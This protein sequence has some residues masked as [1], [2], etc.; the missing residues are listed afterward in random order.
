MLRLDTRSLGTIVLNAAVVVVCDD[1]GPASLDPKLAV[2]PHVC[3]PESGI[4]GSSD[5][6][7]VA[8]GAGTLPEGGQRRQ[9]RIGSVQT[10]SN[11]VYWLPDGHFD[12]L[13]LPS[14]VMS[15][16]GAR[17]AAAMDVTGTIQ[18]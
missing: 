18:Q 2:R 14:S 1:V 15:S 17:R 16:I 13:P 3:V 5:S 10:D 12:L 6:P 7:G 11:A 4:M 8:W 9:S